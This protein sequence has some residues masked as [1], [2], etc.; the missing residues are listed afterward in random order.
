[1]RLWHKDLI[2]VLPRQQLLAQWRECCAIARNIA[3]KD[4][5]GHIL[6]N[7]IMN[8]PE[9]EFWSYAQKVYLEMRSRGYSCDFSAFSRWCKSMKIPETY[10]DDLDLFPGWH[11]K[12]YLWQCYSNLEE[13]HDCGGIPDDEWL[14]IENRMKGVILI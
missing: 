9:N 11:N 13:K 1:M 12:R 7:R 6:V 8:Y 2:D 3:T 10:S 4:T 5:P 14:E